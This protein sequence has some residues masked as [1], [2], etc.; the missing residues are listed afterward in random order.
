MAFWDS[1]HGVVV[2]DPLDGKPELLTTSDGGAHWTA[3]QLN[4]IPT[5]KNGE[6]SPALGTCIA[7]YARRKGEGK[8]GGRGSDRKRTTRL[9]HRRFRQD[10]SCAYKT[11][12]ND[13]DNLVR[14][15]GLE[16]PRF[17]PPDPKSG[18]SANSATFAFVFNNLYA[19]FLV[20]TD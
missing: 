15:G 18:A 10:T 5:A 9:P 7:T 4:T 16:P 6:G 3:L 19:P 17:Y 2:G 13:K 11:L 12:E 20:Q 14:K 1:T 8:T